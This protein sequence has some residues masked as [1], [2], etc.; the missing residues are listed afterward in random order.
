MISGR[1]QFKKGVKQGYTDGLKDN[2][3]NQRDAEILTA[4]L[5][6]IDEAGED[7]ATFETNTGRKV[8]YKK[9]S[10]IRSI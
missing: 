4:T 1:K 3:L 2:A 9:V 10:E 6:Y 7:G 8:T 5:N